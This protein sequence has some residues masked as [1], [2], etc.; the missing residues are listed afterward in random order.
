MKN[1]G[2]FPRLLLRLSRLSKSQFIPAHMG[3]RDASNRPVNPASMTN[4][5]YAVSLFQLIGPSE[6]EWRRIREL[7]ER[8]EDLCRPGKEGNSIVTI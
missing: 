3:D 7:V 1:P 4:P 5:Y 2:W 8:C 6:S